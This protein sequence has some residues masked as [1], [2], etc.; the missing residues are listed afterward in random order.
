MAFN[1]AVYVAVSKIPFGRVT[2][3]GH[4]A[5]LIERPQNSRRVGAA[6]KNLNTSVTALRQNGASLPE[7]PW[8]RVVQS[9]GSIALRDGEHEQLR[10]LQEEGVEVHDMRVSMSEFGWFPEEIDLDEIQ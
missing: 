4:I 10:K 7:I 3:Y 6:L 2:N 1:Y 8:W 5:H 9:L